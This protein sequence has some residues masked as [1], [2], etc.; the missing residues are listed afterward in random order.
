MSRRKLGD[1]SDGKRIRDLDPLFTVMPH[2]LKTRTGS[3]IFFEFE[4]PASHIEEFIKK[5]RQAGIK[6]SI[7]D[8]IIASLV[9][10]YAKKP[11]IHRFIIGKKNYAKNTIEFAMTIKKEMSENAPEA[12]IKVEFEPTATVFDVH[13]KLQEIIQENRGLS[14]VN[15]TEVFEKIISAT[16][17][18]IQSMIVCMILFLDNRGLLPAKII[19]LSPFHASAYIANLGSIG[20][21]PVKHHLFDVGTASMFMTFGSKF[22]KV[23]AD[24]NGNFKE[25]KHIAI[26]VTVDERICDGYNLA[27]AFRLFQRYLKNPEHLTIPFEPDNLTVSLEMEKEDEEQDVL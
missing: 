3:Q 22:K 21:Q 23:V 20:I 7:M 16:P 17:G 2:L 26:C 1:R 10:V 9:R 18:F 14:Q 24:K 5:H 13:N 12:T 15:D 27:L 11:T 6:I 19:K 8:I 25:E 4:M